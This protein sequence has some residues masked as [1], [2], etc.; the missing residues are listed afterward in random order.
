MKHRIVLIANSSAQLMHISTECV[1]QTQFLTA[2]LSALRFQTWMKAHLKYPTKKV[3]LH[4]HQQSV[5]QEFEK[6]LRCIAP[7]K[8]IDVEIAVLRK[9]YYAEQV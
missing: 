2:L 7:A 9:L 6:I 8:V 1:K 5:M 4:H 3:K